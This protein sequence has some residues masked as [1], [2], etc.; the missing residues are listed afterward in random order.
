MKYE[1][2]IC[3][4]LFEP[5]GASPS[6]ISA[7]YDYAI[8]RRRNPETKNTESKSYVCCPHCSDTVWNFVAHLVEAHQSI[9]TLENKRELIRDELDAMIERLEVQYGR[10]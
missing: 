2:S 4:K 9:P 5:W 7:H 6:W 1:C 3:G 8:I 10:G